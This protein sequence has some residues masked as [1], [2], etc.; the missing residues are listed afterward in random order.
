[1]TDTSEALPPIASPRRRR[2]KLRPSTREAIWGYV[3]IA[4]WLIG[5]VLFT[6]GPMVAS[7]VMS[8]T[9]FD[10]LH[11]DQTGSSGSTTT[12]GWRRTRSSSTR[13]WSTFKFAPIVIP[14]TM[15]ASLGFAVLLLNQPNSCVRGG[16]LRDA[17]LHA[18]A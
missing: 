6:A 7:L 15:V 18:D 2:W 5:L 14:L 3:F 4:P 13:S 1:M 11:A 16:T 17:R 8:F 10:L 9:D 12:S